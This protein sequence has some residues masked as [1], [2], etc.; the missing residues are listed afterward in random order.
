MSEPFAVR[1]SLGQIYQ[2]DV[3]HPIDSRRGLSNGTKAGDTFLPLF[4]L[5][6]TAREANPSSLR[7][8]SHGKNLSLTRAR[9]VLG[10]R[11]DLC[12]AYKNNTAVQNNR[13]PAVREGKQGL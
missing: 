9:I 7:S 2:D 13:F 8:N 4:R 5:L 10:S 1:A 12:P 3:A 11:V 6:L